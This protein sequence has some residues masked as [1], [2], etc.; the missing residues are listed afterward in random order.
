M[1]ANILLLQVIS[2]LLVFCQ[3][4]QSERQDAL[5]Q[6]RTDETFIQNQMAEGAG[7]EEMS[8]RSRQLAERYA[9]FQERFPDHDKSP[10]FL[11]QG[12]MLYA[13]MLGEFN[14]SIELLLRLQ[15]DYQEH[16]IA[17]RAL[18]LAGF[19]Y[20]Y[21]LDEP[22]K[23]DELYTRFLQMYP[24]SELAEGVHQAREYSGSDPDQVIPEMMP[25]RQ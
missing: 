23:A 5:E 18:F 9:G 10:D 11:F 6:I 14:K 20:D 4:E 17:E 13:E 3:S 8:D 1:R 22:E 16:E 24:E 19:M 15:Q 21:E 25:P 2:F 12:A 7:T